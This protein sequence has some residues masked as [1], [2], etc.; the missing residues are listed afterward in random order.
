MADL[1][2][3]TAW[4]EALLKARYAGIRTVEYDGKRGC[5]TPPTQKWQPRWP[6]LKRRITFTTQRITQVRINSSKE[7]KL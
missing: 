7:S 4:R 6:I 2:Q 3:L 5:L 1:A